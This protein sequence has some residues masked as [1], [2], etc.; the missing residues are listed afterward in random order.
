MKKTGA[1][2]VAVIELIPSFS[3]ASDLWYYYEIGPIDYV[4][5]ILMTPEIAETLLVHAD[6]DLVP[7]CEP[8][9]EVELGEPIDP[10]A[11]ETDDEDYTGPQEPLAAQEFRRDLEAAKSFAKHA[12]WEGDFVRGPGVFWLP[13][14]ES[15]SFKYAF[16]WK[17]QNNGMTYVVSPLPLPWLGEAKTCR[18]P[19]R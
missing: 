12:G 4:W 3:I 13:D 2:S 18:Q 9:D 1:D 10:I 17:Q 6:D 7:E 15:R 8:G 16:A 19:P 5:N 14:S 11:S